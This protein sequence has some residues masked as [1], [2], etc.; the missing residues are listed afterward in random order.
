MALLDAGIA[1]YF[2]HTRRQ[3][4]AFGLRQYLEHLRLRNEMRRQGGGDA[5]QARGRKQA[6]GDLRH[7]SLAL[8][9]LLPLR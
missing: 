4:F 2:G 3:R 8:R 5:Q 1:K 9:V 7:Q 6:G